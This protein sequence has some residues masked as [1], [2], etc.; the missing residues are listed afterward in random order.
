M[1]RFIILSLFLGAASGAA[2]GQEL[3]FER[4]RIG[5]TTFEACSVFDVDND[6]HLDLV[7]GGVWYPGPEFT[8]KVKITDVEY[9]SEYY[10]DFADYP[11]D[12]NGNGYLDIVTGGWFGKT[13]RWRENPEGRREEW[14]IHDIGEVGNIERGCFWDLN[15]DG[16]VEA[17]PNLPGNPFIVFQ[18]ERDA[19]GR[20][21]GKFL[22]H[23]ISSVKQGHGLGYGDLN[24]DGRGDLISAGGWL[25][26]PEDPF[27][28]E[29]VWH[30]EFELGSASVPILVH[31][32]NGDGKNDLIV[33]QGHDYGLAWYEQGQ[34]EQGARTW[35]KH[36][37]E[38]NLSQFH[39]MYLADL[40][41]DGNL[42]LITGKRWRA[43]NGND[44]GGN[45]PVGLYYY[46]L[47]DGQAH[48]R[49]IDF[50]EAG[51][52]SGTGIYLWTADVSGNGWL[53]ILA[54]GKEGLFLFRNQGFVESK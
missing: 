48:K 53:D 36:D 18:L 19:Q 28:G 11:M 52:H 5:D 7:S 24:G 38:T 16:V 15:G 14:K 27:A 39:E 51:Q 25:E 47:K 1:A 46:I 2:F 6:G 13:L 54:P 26:A 12:V 35:T 43:H 41:R 9:I 49:T 22:R 32:M 33:G 4:Q 3:S 37:I 17:V 30:P 10:D 42:E 45:E 20:G 50:G 29:W 34:D 44:P 8:E 21:T 40:T 31:D 23:D